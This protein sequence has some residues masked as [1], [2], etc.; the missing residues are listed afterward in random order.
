MQDASVNRAVVKDVVQ[1][2][3]R[4]ISFQLS[5]APVHRQRLAELQA[6]ISRLQAGGE[7]DRAFLEKVHW[8]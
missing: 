2:L 4:E 3:Q 6:E 7:V 8:W 5:E 1:K